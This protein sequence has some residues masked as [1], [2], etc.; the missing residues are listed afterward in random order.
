MARKKTL[1][2]SD[3]HSDLKAL[4]ALVATPAD[5]YFAVG[6]LVNWARG[7]D[8]VGEAL[9]PLAGKLSVIPGNHESERD[10]ALFC[11]KYGFENLHKRSVMVGKY[12]LAALGYS[13]PTPFDTP[14]EYTEEEIARYLEPFAGFEPLILVCHCPPANTALDQAAP[15]KHFGSTAIAKFIEKN[16]P[17]YFFCGHIHEA[18]GIEV[19]LGRTRARNLGKKGYLF[20]I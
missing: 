9:R 15:G 5:H 3:I 18:A 6:D 13:N 2:F 7:L 11:E 1:F 19:T 4:A 10:I 8:A 16:Q 20:E 14:G 17:G 12:H